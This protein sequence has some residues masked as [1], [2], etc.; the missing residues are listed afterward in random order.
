M[1]L[2]EFRTVRIEKLERLR[3]AG[4]DPYPISTTRTHRIDDA[5]AQFVTLSGSH[6]TVTVVGRVM[7]QR[8]HGGITFVDLDD[9]SGALQVLCKEDSLGGDAYRLFTETA[10]IGDFLECTG[11]MFDTKRGEHTLEASSWR[12]LSKAIR[13]LPEKFHGLVD[14]EERY[15][16][17]ALDILLKPDVKKAFVTRFRILDLAR[18]FFREHGYTEVETPILQLIPGGATAQ[19]F[20]THLNTLDLEL[21]LRVAPELY[22]KRLL[23]GGMERVF[24]LGKNFRNEGMDREHN[25]EFTMLE[26][27][28]AYQDHEWLMTLTEEFIIWTATQLFGKP[29]F[30]YQGTTVTLASPFRRMTFDQL[31]HEA[32]GLDFDA[33]SVKEFAAKAKE[34]NIVVDKAMTKAN[35]ADEI[36]KKTLRARMMEP[37]FVTGH[38][39]EISP[40]SKRT[41][42]GA[43]TVARFQ[44]IMGGFELA[45]AF[46]ELNDPL[47]QAERFAGQATLREKG[48]EEA[49]RV[50]DNYLE[51]MEYGMP[52]AAGIGI[53]MDRLCALF[54][55]SRSLRDILLFPLMKPRD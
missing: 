42:P 10:D 1:P 54:T 17:R 53:G 7:A 27:Y 34:L 28:A 45:N 22:L 24:E 48:S 21:F 14:V 32:C 3:T 44:L 2:D 47:D 35:I 15:R 41:A 49:H 46:A 31:V 9:G 8:A 5:L 33:A 4:V 11:T 25:P 38:P 37:V 19:P 40:L 23:V 50:D 51:A 30:T 18:Q 55:D 6:A 43:D 20:A 36:Y 16:Q 52:P 26:A 39:L 13:P 29:E 12:M